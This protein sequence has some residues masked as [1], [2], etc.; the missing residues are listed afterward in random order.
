MDSVAALDRRKEIEP[1]LSSMVDAVNT[2]NG[3][4][5]TVAD[6]S[7]RVLALMGFLTDITEWDWP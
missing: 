7:R 6:R 4:S 1:Y 3:E 5:I 2:K